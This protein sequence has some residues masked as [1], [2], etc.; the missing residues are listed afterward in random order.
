[1]DCATAENTEMEMGLQATYGSR[2]HDPA[3]DEVARYLQDFVE[4]RQQV[5]AEAEG[6]AEEAA[7]SSK[8][9]FRLAALLETGAG[10]E[11]RKLACDLVVSVVEGGDL[12]SGF[13]ARYAPELEPKRG[14]G[15]PKGVGQKR[16]K[17]ARQGGHSEDVAAE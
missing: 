16:R 3:V 11:L 8:A 10:D 2:E 14:P 9:L 12:R 6:L 5:A 13:L 17:K 7:E 1:M 15:R 4:V